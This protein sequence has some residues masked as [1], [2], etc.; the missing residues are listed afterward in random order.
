M[1]TYT[2]VEKYAAAYSRDEG[3]LSGKDDS[4]S[5]I[6]YP[7]VFLFIGDKAGDAIEPMIRVNE[8]KWDNS[9]GVMYIHAL[10][11]NAVASATASGSRIV[12]L[13]LPVDAGHAPDKSKTLRRDV[14]RQFHEHNHERFEL[15]RVLRQVSGDIAE[16]G[17][18]YASFD[19]IH[20]AII[21]MVDDP[22]NVLVPEITLLADAIFRQS[23]KSVQMDLYVLINEREQAETFGYASSAGVAFLREVDYMQSPDYAF[24]APLHVTEDGISIE[25]THPASPLF[26]L[27]YVLTDKNERGMSTFA[28]E[29]NYE[30]ICHMNLL[31]NRKQSSSGRLHEM[32]NY[33]NTSLRNNVMTESGRLG[34][35]SAG[36]SKVARPNHSIALA[37]LYHFY[38]GLI[39]RMK[40]A[41][42]RTPA[43]K[44]SW[45]GLDPQA[46]AARVERVVPDEERLSDMNGIMTHNISFSQLKRMTL[47]EAEQALFGSGCNAYFRDNY[48]QVADKAFRDL[49]DG[50]LL[51]MVRERLAMPADTSF[52]QVY[53][54]TNEADEGDS[55]WPLLHSRIRDAGRALE[56]A[57]AE[58]EQKYAETVEEQ[59]FQRVPLLDKHNVRNFIRCFFNTVYRRKREVLRLETELRLYRKYEAELER[60]HEIHAKHVQQMESLEETLRDAALM[61]IRRADDYIGQNIMEYYERVTAD[62]MQEIEAKRGPGTF[63]EERYMGSLAR[64]LEQGTDA[65]A[66]R[67]CEVCRTHI[68]T[69]APFRQTFEEELLQRAN[70]MIEYSNQEVLSK[71]EL[72]K[73]LYR[74]L[75]EHAGIHVRLLD[76]THEHRYEEKY[77]FGDAMSEFMRYALGEEETSRIYKLGCVHEQRSSG[78][79]KLNIMG[80]FQIEDLLY[81]RNGKMYYESYEQNG[82]QFHGIRSE[83]LPP[84]R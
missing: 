30:I 42:E 16:Y 32:D 64:L 1:N 11:R 48:E 17:R 51:H 59:S 12:R 38:R 44:L 37:V 22:L 60:L 56:T 80:G 65:L 73:K 5:S 15:N 10:S 4:Q 50:E 55:V 9:A 40:A 74:M 62:I 82:Y 54:W 71:D 39:D 36:L 70:V 19:R 76:Y 47:R 84:I 41:P 46:I 53:A 2:I 77:F 69:A 35:V 83:V 6:H 8:R 25:V 45:F 43:E 29:D 57:R 61:S 14:H 26:D 66:A 23:F 27:V 34:Y 52:Y 58:L 33:N 24:S 75:E 28:E 49:P 68:L 18:L 72:F 31:K 63:G 81:Y 3:R 13:V 67:L 7:T 79:E 20:L 78:V 21:T